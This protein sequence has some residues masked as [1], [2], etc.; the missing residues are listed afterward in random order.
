MSNKLLDLLEIESN[1]L[2]TA[3]KKASIEGEGTPQ[4]IADRREDYFTSF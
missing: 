3:F 1:E 4:E 2:D